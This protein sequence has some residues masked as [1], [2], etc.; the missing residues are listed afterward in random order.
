MQPLPPLQM[1][2]PQPQAVG[3]VSGELILEGKGGQVGQE[4]CDVVLDGKMLGEG[5]NYAVGFRIPFEVAAGQHLLQLNVYH[6]ILGLGSLMK[7]MGGQQEQ[8]FP[9][10]LDRPGHYKAVLSFAPTVW[11]MLGLR[12]RV[13]TQIQV[14]HTPPRP[15]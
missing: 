15:G 11:M 6:H 1:P 7:K 10:T 12:T 4:R 2:P 9:L 5:F 13:P 3:P 8:V 14:T